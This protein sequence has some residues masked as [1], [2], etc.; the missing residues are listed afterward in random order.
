MQAWLEHLGLE[1]SA[2]DSRRPSRRGMRAGVLRLA[3]VALALACACAPV[4]A[5]TQPAAA[6]IVFS[7]PA[8][9]LDA[10]LK[11]LAQRTPL[12]LF[13]TPEVVAGLQAPA[14]SGSYTPEQA[15]AQL[16]R[17]SGLEQ[18]REGNAIVLQ[19]AAAA[20]AGPVTLAAV[21][22]SASRTQSDLASPT[23][24]T[25]V[26]E[27][28][29]LQELRTG[30]D[31][32]ATVLAKAVPGMADSSRTITDY[33]QTLR[34]RSMLVLVDGIPLNTNRDSARNLAN[35]DPGLIERVEV[36][37]GSSAIYGA[38]ATG[39]IVSITTRPAGGPDVAE[40]TLSATSPL[41]RLRADGLGGQL[42]QHFA[43]S[44]GKLDYA[45]DVGGRHIGSSY[46]ANG[47]RIAPEPSQGDMF[48]A[49][50]FNV[51]AKLGVRLDDNQRVQLSVS[52]YNADQDT[53]YASDPA[54]AR[55]PPGSATARPLDGLQLD[56]QNQI[57]NT[58][59]NLE[60]Q[61]QSLWGSKLSTQVYYRDY[62][63][64]FTPFDARA[65][66]TRGNN[67]D[68]VMQNSHVL[69]S[70]ITVDTPL[71]DAKRTK[72]LWGLDF[73][74]ERSDMP[75]DI[76]DPAAY[77]AS[78]GRVFRRTGTVTYMPELTTR[79][80]GL[81]GQLEHKFNDQWSAQGGVRYEYSSARFDD[82]VPLSQ[83]RVANPQTIKGG[84][85][86]YDALLFNA[87]LAYSPVRGQEFYTSFS[88]G[89]QL[90]DIGVQMRNAR[91]GFDIASSDLQPV[92]T[93]NYELGWRGGFGNTSA[94]LAVFYSTSKLGDVQSFNN[95]LI[96]TRTEEKIFGVEG[97]LDYSTDDDRW[98]AGGTF[99]WT[100]GRETPDGQ[101]SQ[102]MTGYRIPPLKL[103]GYLQYRPNE[104]WSNRVQVTY[105][106]SKDYRLDGVNSFGRREVSSYTTVDLISRYELS[107]QDTLTLG[108][109]NL[110]NRDYY[111]QYSQLMRNSLNSSRLPAAGTVLTAMYTHRW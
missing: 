105:F 75:N 97:S 42:Q 45:F 96:L 6:P 69:G 55:L 95:G 106:G 84:S 53:R 89:F 44:Q 16:L 12:Q 51:G 20:Q 101:P 100:R 10:A 27:R 79:S 28:E 31:S 77:D 39:G 26:I 14:L 41:T 24:Q 104:R 54:V 86:S 90:P 7:M 47:N 4:A 102:P 21:E 78:G 58:L 57:R 68:Q 66:V 87:G 67:V 82:F 38:G 40:T 99:T 48:N 2:M 63:T 88:Q 76:F 11:S 35:I 43:G 93:N 61:H 18:R 32:L 81:F 108:I 37:R 70:R 1:H 80:T 110:F 17:G 52:H 98:G 103:T 23:R 59:V 94:T 25:T 62:Y 34:G 15:L 72:L 111:P 85:V 65:V 22:V 109:E 30:S 74:Q 33:G 49:N 71:G 3:P 56:D 83:S 19:R 91:P 36:L 92:K 29:Q 64:R 5:Q 50:A 46:D 73:N 107:K 60:Y 9:P 8:Q 13:Y